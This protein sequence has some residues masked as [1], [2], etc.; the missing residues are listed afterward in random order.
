[1]TEFKR[2]S[3]LTWRR[4]L[5]SPSGMEGMLFLREHQPTVNRLNQTQPHDIIFDAGKI[6]G[7]RIALDMI[8]NIISANEK[9]EQK[10]YE[11]P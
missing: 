10:S 11:N 7:Y 5:L 6:E 8:E 3:Q 2:T 1:M 4:H 9:E